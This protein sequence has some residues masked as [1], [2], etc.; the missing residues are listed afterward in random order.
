MNILPIVGYGS[1]V[2]RATCEQADN[3]EASLDTV[4]KLI[5]TMG[6][7]KNCAGLAANQINK[8][9][10]IFVAK[11]QGTLQVVINPVIKKRRQNTYTTEGCMS[12]P[13]VFSDGVTRDKILEVEY[14]D[15]DFNR[16]TNR[17]SGF[18]AILFQHEYDHLYGILYTDRLDDKNMELIKHKLVEIEEAKSPTYYDMIFPDKE[19]LLFKEK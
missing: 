15:R 11:L 13:D 8:T 5:A 16:V 18:D 4:I 17:L 6:S 1:S 9:Q 7:L 3:N 10:K 19:I 2:L 14:Y 12:I